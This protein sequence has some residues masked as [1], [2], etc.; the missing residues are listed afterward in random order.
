MVDRIAITG[1]GALTPVG[2]GVDA[3]WDALCSGSSGITA[4]DTDW[5]QDVPV[6]IAGTIDE[7]FQD[8]LSVRERRST[9]RAE[10]F[11]LVAGREAWRDAGSPDVDGDRLAVAYGTAIGGVTTTFGQQRVLLEQGARRVSP[12]TVTMLMAN[13]PAALLSIDIGA[14]GGART[15][16]SA[17][18]SGSE[19]IALGREMILAGTVDVVVAGGVEASVTALSMAAFA[20]MRAMSKRNDAPALASRPFDA[21][22]DGFVLGEGAV[23]FVLERE[24]HA[25]ARGATIHGFVSGASVTSDAYQMVGADVDNQTRTIRLA[26]RS[27]GLDAPDIGLV[28]AHATA[29]VQGDVSEALALNAAGIRAPVTATKS[30]TGHLLGGSGALG[31]LVAIRAL[32]ERI[33]PP[34]VNLDRLGDGIDLDVVTG[35]PRAVRAQHALVNAFGFGG[36]NAAVVLS[37]D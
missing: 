25:R 24:G 23:T 12:H 20:Q 10:Q 13:G 1:I 14:R 33:I 4:L 3:T 31:A 36:H 27:A 17:C 26:L 11:G 9:D 29:T 18:A 32:G 19:A 2:L 16:I 6:R 22:R 15:V 30:M 7:R 34:T 8:A 35:A 37:R 5:A 21:D 28:H